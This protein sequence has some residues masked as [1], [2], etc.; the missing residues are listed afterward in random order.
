MATAGNQAECHG[1]TRRRVR[2][3]PPPGRTSAQ[4]FG[5]VMSMTKPRRAVAY[6]FNNDPDSLPKM[7]DA[8]R[9]TYD[10][11]LDFA[12]DFMVWNVT[13]DSIRTR[14]GVPDPNRYPL[15]PPEERQVSVA[16]DR[17]QTPQWIMDGLEPEVLPIVQKIYDDFISECG[18]QCNDLLLDE[19]SQ[20]DTG[21]HL[22][23]RANLEQSARSYFIRETP[24]LL[25]ITGQYSD[26]DTEVRSLP[27][28]PRDSVF[29]D[30]IQRHL[31]HTW[32]NFCANSHEKNDSHRQ[33]LKTQSPRNLSIPRA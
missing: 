30:G 15:P 11:P 23:H 17:Y 24:S 22:A 25:R 13:K 18:R 21:V 10:G 28:M 19:S 27:K 20:Q 4:M 2:R 9:E 26:G 3:A 1:G 6:H 33:R 5:K 14:L 31:R 12:T 7:V 8:V 29:N 16:D 32:Y